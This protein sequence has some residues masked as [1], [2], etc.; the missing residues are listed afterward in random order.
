[1]KILKENNLMRFL[2]PRKKSL[3]QLF[4][5]G[6]YAATYRDLVAGTDL[7]S[8]YTSVGAFC[9]CWPNPLFDNEW[10]FSQRPDLRVKKQNPLLHYIEIGAMEG[11]NPHPLFDSAWYLLRNPDVAAS[12]M[13]PLEHYLLHGGAEGRHPSPLFDAAW[14]MRRYRDAL[15]TGANPLIH[16][17]ENGYT[18]DFDPNPFFDSRWYIERY[19]AEKNGRTNPFLHFIQYGELE[20]NNPSKDF[21]IEWYRTRYSDLTHYAGSLFQHFLEFGQYEDRRTSPPIHKFFACEPLTTFLSTLPP[22]RVPTL[23]YMEMKVDSIQNLMLNNEDLLAASI[24]FSSTNQE[25]V[26]LGKIDYPRAPFVIKLKNIFAVS[27]TRYLIKKDRVFHDEEDFYF[28]VAGSHSKYIGATRLNDRK[29]RVEAHVRPAAWI[30]CGVNLMHEYSSN[31]FH[32]IAETIPRMMLSEEAGIPPDVPYLFE[33]GLSDNI[34]GMI[35]RIVGAKRSTVWLEPDTLFHVRELYMPSD[36]SSVVDAYDG[37]PVSMTSGLDISRIRRGVDKIRQAETGRVPSLGS[38]IYLSRVGRARNPQNQDE[39]KERLSSLGFIIVDPEKL[40]LSEQIA[41]LSDAEIV[42][43]PTGAQLAN[44]VWCQPGTKVIVLASDHPSQQLYL[45]S[46]LGN[47]SGVTVHTLLGPRAH[48]LSGKY[49][50]H[51]DYLVPIDELVRLVGI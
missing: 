6:W 35:S 7:W 16:F 51:D 38:R 29:V 9:N 31:Y 19:L 15:T 4:D 14:Y 42:V 46:L 40:T 49:G 23:A 18:G 10:Y 1:M 36:L 48:V 21:D 3:P 32:F 37:G 26:S 2:R 50:V 44:I 43:G 39:I 20:N 8:H 12:G 45:W 34:Q 11:T 41:A 5:S 47:S 17:I 25:V 27:G 33:K 24:Q 13:N 22:S 28:D 30:D